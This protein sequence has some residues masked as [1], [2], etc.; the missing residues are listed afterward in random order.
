MIDEG[1]SGFRWVGNENGVARESEW[2]PTPY[3]ADPETRYGQ[4][5]IIGGW[6]DGATAEDLGSREK[7]TDPLVRYLSWMPAEADVSI[8]PGWFH[9]ADE[10]PKTADELVSL[11][12]RSV[13]RNSLLLLNVPPDASGRIDAADA[14]E[15]R[16]F[17]DAI[18]RTYRHNLATG[19]DAPELADQ[20]LATAWRLP[21]TTGERE[22]A[23]G[24]L[25]T[26]DQVELGED[27]TRGQRAGRGRR[28]A[29]RRLGR[30][31]H[32]DHRGPA[33]PARARRAGRDRPDPSA[34]PAIPRGAA[35]EHAR[36]LPQRSDARVTAFRR[37]WLR[38][39]G[40]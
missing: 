34:R 19:S 29:G 32:R 1:P 10:R 36:P 18:R 11:Y 20:D 26:F 17:G 3:T 6:P 7:I 30:G 21:G 39:Y 37:A 38:R 8:R 27:V 25:R 13:G 22:V 33:P 5:A 24:G 23:L 4:E 9:H 16:A 31:R 15:L 35:P 2:S 12:Q 28:A 40:L 14:T